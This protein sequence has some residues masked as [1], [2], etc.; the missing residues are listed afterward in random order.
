MALPPPRQPSP[1]HLPRK[2]PQTSTS[3]SPKA[4]TNTTSPDH[5]RRRRLRQ[6]RPREHPRLARR[7][8]PLR[9]LPVQQPHP[10]PLHI[11]LLASQRK[12]HRDTQQQT[13]H[14]QSRPGDH[15][16]RLERSGSGSRLWSRLHGRS[17]AMSVPLAWLRDE[18]DVGSE[19]GCF[20]HYEFHRRW[21]SDWREQVSLLSE[22]Y[23]PPL[24]L[25]SIYVHN[26]QTPTQTNNNKCLF[27]ITASRHIILPSDL[28]NSSS[29]TES[30]IVVTNGQQQCC[31]Y[32]ATA[33]TLPPQVNPYFIGWG[34]EPT[35][36]GWPLGGVG[37]PVWWQQ[38]TTSSKTWIGSGPE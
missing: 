29:A 38:N 24:P 11:R 2:S 14:G 17:H 10:C 18:C 1:R 23:V 4:P 12:H 21:C 32:N 34:H 19:G 20:V 28:S 8:R 6:R 33:P 16:F 35:L 37:I 36:Y 26:H 13:Q 5:G 31:N 30:T 7:S 9:Q 25:L 3:P 15:F 22:P 27:A